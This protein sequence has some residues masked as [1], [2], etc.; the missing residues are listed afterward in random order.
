MRLTEVGDR[1]VP[2]VGG[3]EGGGEG[4]GG[5]DFAV[6]VVVSGDAAAEPSNNRQAS[7]DV[8]EYRPVSA[9]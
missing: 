1:D 4:F 3:A 7:H 9:G 2:A 5:G 8:L 6:D